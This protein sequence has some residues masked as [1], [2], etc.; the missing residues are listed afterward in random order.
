MEKQNFDVGAIPCLEKG[1]LFPI[2]S[3]QPVK[4]LGSPGNSH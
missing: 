1:T 3:Y 2:M 4:G